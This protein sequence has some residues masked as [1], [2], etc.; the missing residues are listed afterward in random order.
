MTD[1]GLNTALPAAQDRLALCHAALAWHRSV[2]FGFTWLEPMNNERI[3]VG[4]ILHQVK[5]GAVNELQ[6][7]LGRSMCPVEVWAQ[8]QI[9][10]HISFQYSILKVFKKFT[11]FYGTRMCM[12]MEACWSLF[13]KS[14]LQISTRSS[15]II[16]FLMSCLWCRVLIT[17][18]GLFFLSNSKFTDHNHRYV[19]LAFNNL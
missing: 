3:S 4:R 14:L 1:G 17:C 2:A 19:W 10:P 16:D 13:E 8:L 15:I 7:N 5:A 9:L 12:F 11:V 18:C 6:Q